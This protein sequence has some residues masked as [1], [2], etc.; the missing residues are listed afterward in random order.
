MKCSIS[1]SFGDVVD[2]VT[3]L[4]IKL[5]KIKNEE[6]LKNIKLEL[7]TIQTELPLVKE[8]NILFNTLQKVNLVIFL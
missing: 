8:E 5:Q 7:D 6:A 1:C 4:K 2:K 3:I